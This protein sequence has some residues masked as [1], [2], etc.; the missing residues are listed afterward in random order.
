MSVVVSVFVGL[1]LWKLCEKW[2]QPSAPKAQPP[3]VEQPDE[4]ISEV[5]PFLHSWDTKQ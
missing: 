2:D 1:W 4:K 5:F 3:P